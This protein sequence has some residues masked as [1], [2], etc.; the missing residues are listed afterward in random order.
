MMLH[1]CTFSPKLIAV[2]EHSAGPSESRQ[3]D[4]YRASS[5]P[6]GPA[7]I[8]AVD[9]EG[10][11]EEYYHGENGYEHDQDDSEVVQAVSFRQ[12]RLQSP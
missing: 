10:F 12:S 7:D 1:S 9:Y 6:S 11:E 8:S 4:G 3:T 5:R 2:V